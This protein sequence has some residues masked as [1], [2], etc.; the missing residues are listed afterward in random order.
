MDA[1]QDVGVVGQ[2]AAGIARQATVAHGA[3]DRFA[4]DHAGGG[5]EPQDGMFEDLGGLDVE[6]ADLL[7]GGLAGLP[8]EMDRPELFEFRVAKLA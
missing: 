7:A 5:R 2:N 6:R 1:D 4:D 8:S 3:P